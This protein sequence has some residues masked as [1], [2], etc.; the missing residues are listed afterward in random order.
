MSA[1]W[2]PLPA[3]EFTGIHWSAPGAIDGQ[4]P[5]L[6]WAEADR[7]AGYRVAPKG[8]PPKWLPIVI[9]LTP[10]ASVPALVQASNVKWL[11]IPRV[12][13]N[14]PG[15]R[16]CTAH[17]KP[18]FF[19]RLRSDPLLR[20]LIQR[21]ELGLPVGHHTQPIHDPCTPGS[22]PVV[23]PDR[24]SGQVLGLIDGGLAFANQA[25]LNARGRT[26]VKHFW[27]QDDTQDGNWPGNEHGAQKTGKYFEIKMFGSKGVLM[28]GGDD[29]DPTSGRLELRK[30]DCSESYISEGFLMENTEA[31]GN[32]PESLLQFIAACRGLPFRNGANQEVGLQAVLAKRITM[33][34]FIIYD[35]VHKLPAYLARV[36][37]WF[38]SGEMVFHED[39]VPGIENAPAALIGMMQGEAIGKRLV[40]VAPE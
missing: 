27:R 5:Y 18:R 11:Q 10:G 23:V 33:T 14:L 34:G 37:P 17:A 4:D 40:Q 20:S 13:L 8:K 38:R 3:G 9:E 24:L 6:A 35:H 26:R 7:F 31:A 16:F 36:A 15:L 12:Y 29:K 28:Y 19:E 30:L 22:H 25:F 32:G 1:A 2:S 21:F 39:I